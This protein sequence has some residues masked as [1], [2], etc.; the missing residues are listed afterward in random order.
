[1]TQLWCAE[2]YADQAAFVSEL[3]SPV[4]AL[5]DVKRGDKILDLGCGDGTL[6]LQIKEL[7]AEV[8]A[9]DASDSMVAAARR[10]GLNASV[11]D[12]QNLNFEAEF[13]AVFS[14]AALHWM[15]DYAAVI[16]GVHQALKPNGQFVGEL[17]GAGN[18]DALLE[19]IAAV[20]A[21]HPDWGK[22][23]NPWYFP[24]P[25]AYTQ[26][27]TAGGFQV[28]YI[29]L[30]PRPTPLKAGVKAWLEMFAGEAIA[31]LPVDQ[32]TLFLD[33]VT[34]KVKPSL[35]TETAGWV[36]DYVRLRFIARK[37]PTR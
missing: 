9:V 28:D 34:A 7:G 33:Q 26:A 30:I 8:V 2:E 25:E 32:R 10:K 29:E 19:A 5:L 13:D 3:A 22:F 11:I 4:L 6:A 21:E 31:K 15:K 1:M 37:L 16:A 35:Y 27:L 12:G 18:I 23:D 17:G 24:T 20:F 14:N 36:A